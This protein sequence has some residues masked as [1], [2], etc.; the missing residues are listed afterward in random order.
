MNETTID[1]TTA[2]GLHAY[3]ADRPLLLLT[4]FPA[5]AA[6]GGAVILRSLLEPD[7][8]RK[9]VWVSTSRPSGP[10]PEGSVVLTQGSAA[11]GKRS[12]FADSTKYA[13]ALANEVRALAQARSAQGL[14][15]VMHGAMVH[16]AAKLSRDGSWPLHLTVHDD[17]TYAGALRS[18]RYFLLA[19][20]VSR[21]FDRAMKS[22]KSIDGVGA[23]MAQRY[24]KRLGVSSTI[25]HRGVATPVTPSPAYDPTQGL[26]LAILG[27]PYDYK[28]MKQMALAVE[29]ASQALNIAGS[30]VVMGKSQGER[31]RA[32][33][34][35]RL[36]VE[37]TGHV[38]E[39]AAIEHL[40]HCFALYL[41]YPFGPLGKV[42]RETSFPTK[43]STYMMAAR[44]LLVHTPP[45]G[46]VMPIT[47]DEPEYA[48]AWTH[49]HPSAGG[50]V[51]KNMWNNPQSFASQHE[52]ADRV[53]LHYYNPTRNRAALLDVL[54]ALPES[55]AS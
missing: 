28:S 4:D 54:N 47:A 21:D 11:K 7:D 50:N 6:G 23:G 43:L 26:R 24:R 14:W 30:V 36:P 12:L 53:R 40:R 15:I 25:V 19:P 9:I 44:P 13:G 29:Q 41:S 3:S 22:A 20:W 27:N 8:W 33:M 18:K 51:L 45:D 17:P 1:A 39:P 2:L 16:V 55:H 35:G 48:Y 52:A 46:S 37:I 49:A 38:A 31:L 10:A 5:D 34:A 42:L 32:D